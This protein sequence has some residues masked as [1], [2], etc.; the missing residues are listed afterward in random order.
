MADGPIIQQAGKHVLEVGQT[1]E[2]T[3]EDI[4]FFRQ[5]NKKTPLILMGYY[6][7]IYI[8]GQEKFIQKAQQNGV[9][10]VIIVDL[11]SKKINLYMRH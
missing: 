5:S 10:G 9:N 2:K 6:N 8:Y 7:S 11:P 3:F 4:A 1:L